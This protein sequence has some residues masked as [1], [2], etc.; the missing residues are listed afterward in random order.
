MEL[1]NSIYHTLK[2]EIVHKLC[3]SLCKSKTIRIYNPLDELYIFFQNQIEVNISHRI[4]DE[5]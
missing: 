2:K 1:R 5:L 3:D 4:K